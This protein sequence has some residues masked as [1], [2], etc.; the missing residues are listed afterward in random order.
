MCQ[1]Y[2]RYIDLY[3]RLVRIVTLQLL[4]RV[5]EVQWE[6]SQRSICQLRSCFGSIHH[7]VMIIYGKASANQKASDRQRFLAN[8][9]E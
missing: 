9:S 2:F 3:P 6:T 5:D 4:I 8:T 7:S 1:L